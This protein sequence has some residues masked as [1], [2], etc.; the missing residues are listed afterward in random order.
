MWNNIETENYILLVMLPF[1]LPP[2]E[3][4]MHDDFQ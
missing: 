4:K 3:G 2:F 1:L